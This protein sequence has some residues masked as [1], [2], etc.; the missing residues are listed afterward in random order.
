MAPGPIYQI[1]IYRG[2]SIY[3]INIL[4]ARLRGAEAATRA[5]A[6]KEG[7]GEGYGDGEG[8]RERPAPGWELA[9]HRPFLGAIQFRLLLSSLC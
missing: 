3:R 1:P 7:E 8:E 6:S 5:I 4:A 2:I 9:E